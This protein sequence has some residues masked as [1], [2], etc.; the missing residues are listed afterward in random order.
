MK[1]IITAFLGAAFA[2]GAYAAP[3]PQASGTLGQLLGLRETTKAPAEFSAS[4]SVPYSPVFKL[5]QTNSDTSD[6]LKICGSVVYP[7][8]VIGMWSYG[9]DSW[10]PAQLS[11]VVYATG[12]GF[13]VKDLYYCNTYR[14]MMGF[15]EI[16]TYSY[17]T[18]DWSE[19]DSFDGKI[20]Y[21]ATTMAYNKDRD[22]AFGCFINS[23]RNGYNFVQWNYDRFLPVKTICAIERPWSGCAFSSD[24]TLYAIERN[25]DLYTVD[26]KTGAMTLVGSTGVP[27]TYLG[28][29][30]IDPKTDTMYWSVTTDTDFGLYSVDIRTATAHKLYTMEN[31]EQICGMYIPD[32]RVYAD[33]V[34]AAVSSVSPTFSGSN[35][36]GTVRFTM[37]RYT[38]GPL[39]EQTRLSDDES[40]TYTV[41]ANGKVIATGTELPGTSVA[42]AVEMP[43]PDSYNF[44]VTVSNA[45]GE[46]PEKNSKKFVG[47]DVPQAPSSFTLSLDGA[48]VKLAWRSPSSTGVNGGNVEYS[49]AT[50]TIV[51]YPDEKVLLDNGTGTSLT[52]V[53]E[54]PEKRTEYYYTLTA[55]VNGLVSAT[56]KSDVLAL[57]PIDPPY[58][59]TFSSAVSLAGWTLVGNADAT[60]KW[61][62]YSY[63][64]ALRAYNSS[65]FDDWAVSPAVN[66]VE[67][68][69]YPFSLQVKTSSYYEETF[70]VCW[71]TAPTAEAMTN[72]VIPDTKLKSTTYT[73]FTGD[74]VAGTTGQI[75]VGI[76]AKTE[77][78]SSAVFVSSFS[79][80]E[81]KATGAPAA[82]SDFKVS[83]PVDGTCEATL[84]FTTPTTD[85]AGN[86]LEDDKAL[87]SV[88]ILRDGNVIA[89]LTENLRG[90]APM[91]Y[92]DKG[93]D[94]TT[95]MHKYGVVAV[96]ALGRGTVTEAEVLIGAHKPLAPAS[97]TMIEEG[98]TGKVTI[99]WDAVTTDVD[100]NEFKPDAVTYRVVNRNY[101]TVADNVTGT[102]ITVQAVEEGEQA[103]V[104]FGVYAVTAGGESDKLTGTAYK[105]VGK[106]YETPWTESFAGRSISSIFGYNYIK[107]SEPW[108]FV[109]S[110]DWGIAPADEDG[111]FAYF[112]AYN[113]YTA[114]VTGKISLEGVYN[115][116]FTYYTYNYPMS[117]GVPTNAI[118]VEADEGDGRGFV[119]VQSNV[120]AETGEYNQWN[121]VVVSLADY[122]GKSVVLR[123][124]PTDAS[125]AFYT[126]DNLRVASYVESNLTASR[127]VAPAVADAG[128]EFE[129]D[130]TVANTGEQSVGSYTVELQ[131]NGETVDF[132]DCGRIDAVASRVVTFTQVLNAIDGDAATYKAVIFSSSDLLEADNETSEAT[133]GIVAAAVPAVTDLSASV[134]GA[135]IVL[136][137]TRPDESTA[138]AEAFTEGFESA[139][140]W[141]E[142]VAGWKIVDMDKAPVG[143]IQVTNF[144]ITGMSS[145]AVADRQWSGFANNETPERWDAHQGFKFICSEYVQRGNSPVQSDD[146]AISPQLY[147]GPQ[148]LSFYAKSFDPAYLE[149]FE[150]LYS[151]NSTNTDD[152]KSVGSAIDVP[153]AWT[154]YRF[155]LPDGA[156][157]FAIRS[158]STN[159]F[160]L[161]IDDVTFIPAEG[162]PA[163]VVLSGYN[164]YRNGNKVNSEL[165]TDASYTD[166]GVSADRTHSYYVTAVYDKGE[167]RRSNEATVWVSGIDGVDASALRIVARDGA[168]AVSGLDDGDVTVY[169]VD[170]RTVATARC[171]NTVSIPVAAGIYLVKAAG[172]TVKVAVK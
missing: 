104:Q 138:P 70:E 140:S 107:G 75:Y 82:V 3:A 154:Q 167:S 50:Y 83:S 60:S 123:I 101:E 62:Y 85:I 71:G 74:I 56:V 84:S 89:T 2:V 81:G 23:E 64:K 49:K 132:K 96:N 22:E 12:G 122:E 134:S 7:D 95:G 5:L 133:V 10:N 163:Q 69:V 40:L 139:E 31:E 103:F 150:V 27:S 87:T 141:S 158:R 164:V 88:E 144:P 152:F 86:A 34:P 30:I 91:E 109:S 94:L 20:E 145:W 36:S 98:N 18:A 156:R 66:V 14:E 32:N 44:V 47:P 28:D 25:G 118:L 92:T 33:N 113:V 67:G 4:A 135:D 161:F 90:G 72:V 100:G 26:T 127:I 114:L 125:L 159:K 41:K 93:E 146:W 58:E 61:A 55:T 168:I 13:A 130:V 6:E 52:D 115:P 121:K 111:G 117:S 11:R 99:T 149:A 54:V 46:S 106:P 38:N 102:S 169:A 48:N 112:E 42:A 162:T 8:N 9:T 126:L 17:K 80:G 15:E 78:Q 77:G 172:K 142:T 165:V 16:K 51:R 65:G 128:K 129:I 37:P 108:Q 53:I 110:S 137:W 119:E 170:G 59:G 39:G 166:R 120:V 97:A 160:F 155:M 57:G 171:R 76:H 153:N 136:A 116:A 24:G 157:Y 19:Y 124:V 1:R 63:E 131:R 151:D 105:P 68:S 79:I 45:V 143:G 29:A 43:E 73:D 35:L 148:A 147:G 21:V